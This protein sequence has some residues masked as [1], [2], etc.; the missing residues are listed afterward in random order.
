MTDLRAT[1]ATAGLAPGGTVLR[2]ANVLALR[3]IRAIT[4]MPAAFVPA[5]LMPVFQA[6]AFSGTFYAITRIPG[7]PTDRSINW[8][9]PLACC[10]GSGFSGLGLGFSAIRDLESGFFDRLRMA[11]TPRF[12]L[13]LGPLLACWARVLVVVAVVLAIGVAMGARLTDGP[14][15]L[16]TL[17]VACIGISTIAAGWGLGLAYRFRDMRAAALMQLTLFLC[18]F[19]T[20]AQAPLAIMSGWL[21]AVARVNPFTNILRLA[22]EGFVGGVTWDG[23]W[24]GLLA[25]AVL[26]VLA[27]QFALSGISRLARS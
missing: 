20:E 12:S 22:R 5:M 24:G 25:L 14:I 3:G 9:L 15:G 2:S 23:T 11:P 17:L 6:V 10:M 21:H 18:L 13:V 4:R 1:P 27:L 7:F 19:L 8:Y 16:L 26:S